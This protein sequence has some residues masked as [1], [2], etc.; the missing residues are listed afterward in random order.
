MAFSAPTLTFRH[1][2]VIGLLALSSQAAMTAEGQRSTAGTESTTAFSA[3]SILAEVERAVSNA[4]EGRF[5]AITPADLARLQAAQQDIAQL[6]AGRD[7]TDELSLPEQIRLAGAQE[8]MMVII[9][10][11]AKAGKTCEKV[12]ATGSRL[13]RTE[14][15]TPK[16]RELRQIAVEEQR[17]NFRSVNC[18]ASGT[19][20]R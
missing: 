12:R 1:L 3:Q 20:C 13:T 9:Q 16:Q 11:T 7:G 17:N 2:C 18:N 8:Q 19:Q 10:G 14:C 15:L 4:R 5:G 6:L